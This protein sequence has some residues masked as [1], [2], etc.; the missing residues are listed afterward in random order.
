MVVVSF[1]TPE[2]EY[3]SRAMKLIEQCKELGL[4]YDIQERPSRN[5]W[6]ANT[7]MKARYIHDMLKVHD[8]IMWVDCDGSLNK[9]P[10]KIMNQTKPIAV[11]RHSTMS[12]HSTDSRRYATGIIGIKRCP[13]SIELVWDWMKYSEEHKTTD[14]L[15]FERVVYDSLVQVL[16]SSY[17]SIMGSNY[18]SNAVYGL[19]LSTAPDKMRRKDKTGKLTKG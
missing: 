4:E 12:L 2:W 9:L 10:T 5:D 7:A 17:L 18:D 14:E 15:A 1:Y 11:T 13:D 19:G 6:I 3:K 16:P 8:H